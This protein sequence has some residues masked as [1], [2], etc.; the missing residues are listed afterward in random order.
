MNEEWYTMSHDQKDM[1]SLLRILN[2]RRAHRKDSCSLEISHANL[3][4]LLKQKLRSNK[5]SNSWQK[6]WLCMR[7]CE[8][9]VNSMFE[10]YIERDLRRILESITYTFL[11]NT[12]ISK[13]Y[14]GFS[15][16]RLKSS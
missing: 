8:E 1:S 13:W 9:A 6:H 3:V 11:N 15:V 5:H 4:D 14:L 7:V 10:T 12:D 2:S 16:D